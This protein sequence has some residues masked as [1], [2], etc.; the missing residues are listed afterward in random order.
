MIGLALFFWLVDRAWLAAFRRINHARYGARRWRRGSCSS[1]SSSTRT[2]TTTSSR[3]RRRGAHRPDRARSPPVR[4]R[5]RRSR[6]PTSRACDDRQDERDRDSGR[7]RSSSRRTPTTASSGAAGRWRASSRPAATSATS[8]SRSRRARCRRA[9]RPTRS[10]GRCARR[11]PSSGFPRASLTVH[12]FDVRTFPERRQDILELLVALWEEWQPDVVFQPSLHDVHQDH[13]TVAEEGL[14]AFKRTTILGYEIPWNNFDFAV[15]VV[16]RARAEAHRAQGRGARA[17]RLAAAP[18]LRER[19]VRA[20]PRAHARRQR[21]PRVRRGLP[22]V[23]RRRLSFSVPLP[24]SPHAS[25]SR[26]SGDPDHAL[27]RRLPVHAG[28][29]VERPHLPGRAGRRS[30]RRTPR[31]PG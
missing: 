8:R 7:R 18:P 16:R 9:S 13:R 26:H 24:I 23:P 20:E 15:P 29:A 31:R 28:A 14:R 27:H 11:R 25:R 3:I 22:G 6:P 5:A 2:R 17:V 30:R 21:E 19:G 10:R 4:A 12:D 1:R